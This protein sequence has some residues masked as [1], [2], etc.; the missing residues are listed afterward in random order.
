MK[1]VRVD[2][3]A[4]QIRGVTFAKGD[5]LDHPAPGYRAVLRAG[6][7]Q[8]AGLSF[9]DLVYVPTERISAKQLVRENDVL[10][11]ASSGSID[12]VGKSA[13]SRSNFDG[14]FGAFLKVLRPLPSVDPSYFAHFFRTRQ[15]RQTI[16]A[17]AAGANINNLKNEHL[18]GLQLPLPS[19]EE[20]RRIAAILDHADSL[21]TYRLQVFSR[22]EA[23]RSSTLAHLLRNAKTHERLLIDLL[24]NEDRLNY[25]VVQPG[26][27]VDEGVPLIRVSDL[28]NGRVDRSDL[29]KIGRDIDRAYARS[30]LNGTEVL[31]VCVGA[32][33]GTIAVAGPEDV[34][35]N[36]ARAVARVPVLD[37]DLRKFVAAYLGSEEPQHYFRG[38]LRTVAQPTLNIKQLAETPVPVPDRQD[39][40]RISTSLSII[41][42]Q[43][44]R[45]RSSLRAL[46]RLFVSLQSRAFRGEL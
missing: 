40:T 33:I 21:R 32:T 25:G 2:D 17:L 39:L 11:A 6:N 41:D 10:I 43:T 36:V 37:P 46:D 38:E 28:K 3:V 1:V 8:E 27:D 9:D 4:D 23:L 24:P 18:D 13:R 20:Q 12:V 26:S 44:A 7:I 14:G 35:S 45:A 42:L 30:R 22:L 16:S 34:G 31:V 29:K 5:A 15:Y 19:L